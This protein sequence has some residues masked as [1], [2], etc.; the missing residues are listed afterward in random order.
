MSKISGLLV[1]SSLNLNVPRYRMIPYTIT[2]PRDWRI[3]YN[4]IRG[5]VAVRSSATFIDQHENEFLSEDSSTLPFA[6]V[7]YSALNVKKNQL[8]TEIKRCLDSCRS[9]RARAY[10]NAYDLPEPKMNVIIQQMIQ[11][12]V[13]GVMFTADPLTGNTNKL[14][15][16]SVWGLGSP[17]V[18]GEITPDRWEYTTGNFI[19]TPAYQD[20]RFALTMKH[21]KLIT[22][23]VRLPLAKRNAPK[24]KRA[25]IDS[26]IKIGGIIEKHLGMSQDIEW[27]IDKDEKIWV[28]QTRP[29]VMRQM[30]PSVIDPS[31]PFITGTG[32]SNGTA[33][34]KVRVIF[35]SQITALEYGEVLV[36]EMT[37]PDFLP[38]LIGPN[39]TTV[40]CAI[41]T[42]K[43]GILSHPAIFSR[44]R[45][46]P[47]VTGTKD[48]TLQLKNGN[49]VKVDGTEGKVY[50][51]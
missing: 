13:S 23:M 19:Y 21:G 50:R 5:F 49:M 1:L 37:T 24:L 9:E 8:E 38:I 17:L 20:K 3:I 36:T 32:V 2:N 11:A 43:G 30:L 45:G 27:A 14:I 28:L 40:P 35:P 7:F 18:S 31:V 39:K 4:Q 46:I 29:I 48:A 33:S 25:T 6:G 34:G 41:I 47:C 16:E 15:I 10:C 44:Q 22:T 42:D 12:E 26:L 51:I